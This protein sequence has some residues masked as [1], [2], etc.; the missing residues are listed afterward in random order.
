MVGCPCRV[1]IKSCGCPPAIR[2][3]EEEKAV[4]FDKVRAVYQQRAEAEPK[5]YRRIDASLSID[6]VQEQ[7][8]HVLAHFLAVRTL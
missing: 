2:R 4:F 3:F 8:H 1:R 5:R 6:E 7:I